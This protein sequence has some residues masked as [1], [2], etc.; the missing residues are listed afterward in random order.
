MPPKS[1]SVTNAIQR[2]AGAVK[3]KSSPRKAA[4]RK[5]PSSDDDSG[6]DFEVATPSKRIRAS[7]SLAVSPEKAP[8]PS[9]DAEVEALPAPKVDW[10]AERPEYL[11]A[12]LTF[13]YEEAERHLISV[14]HRWAGIFERLKCRPFVQLER[15][16][17]FRTLATSIIGQQISWKA[18]RSVNWKF[19]R[20]YDDTLPETV[21]PPE[22]YTAPER[23][24]PPHVVAE[25]SLATLRSA[26]LSARKAEY[27]QD[28]AQ[29]FSDGRLSA[30]KLITAS[31]EELREAL[32]AVRGIGPWTI[33]MF[34]IFS[35]RRPNILPTGDLGVQR[36]LLRWVLSQ[37]TNPG[38]PVKLSRDK[39]PE[40]G[41]PGTKRQETPEIMDA[42]KEQ[43]KAIGSMGP[44]QTPIKKQGANGQSSESM[45]P[46][47]M[48]PSI[49]RVLAEPT[50]PTPLPPGLTVAAL[51]ARLNGRNKGKPPLSPDE[52]ES[53]TASWK[54]YRSLGVWYMWSLVDQELDEE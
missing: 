37:H 28:L 2:A 41:A 17:P 11:P 39:L 43:D 3:P 25:T 31:D 6:S 22:E 32:I 40:D 49:N 4:K 5:A 33:D 19:M 53:L 15:V 38:S 48:T 24:P 50:Q 23:F 51:K 9:K 46:E 27:I 45:I 42:S 13:S 21:P 47:P 35:L 26:G 36:G 34:A 18:A 20:L 52:M 54:P 44:P 12:S 8:K 10:S 29:H 30:E 14:D 16:D 1:K 7:R